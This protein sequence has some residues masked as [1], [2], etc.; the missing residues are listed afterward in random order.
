M[1]AQSGTA[2]IPSRALLLGKA[3]RR[4]LKIPIESVTFSRLRRWFDSSRFT[5]PFCDPLWKLCG[6]GELV[7][8]SKVAMPSR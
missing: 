1:M 8:L 6:N 4:L 5:F 7:F 3:R 2:T